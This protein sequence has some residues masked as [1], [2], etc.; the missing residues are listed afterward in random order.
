M[1]KKR[2]IKTPST[3]QNKV[4]SPEAIEIMIKFMKQGWSLLYA[5]A[6]A[7]LG[8]KGSYLA[9]TLSEELRKLHDEYQK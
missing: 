3:L 5:G 8:H 7:G 1:Y 6:Q 9:I 4:V 2:E